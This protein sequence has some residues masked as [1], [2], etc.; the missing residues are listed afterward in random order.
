MYGTMLCDKFDTE[1]W[2][3]LIRN[4]D[5]ELKNVCFNKRLF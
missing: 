1:V 3:Q 2:Y 5:T 4:F